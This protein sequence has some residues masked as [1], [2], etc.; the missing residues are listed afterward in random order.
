MYKIYEG[1]KEIKQFDDLVTSVNYAMNASTKRKLAYFDVVYSET[2]EVLVE[3]MDGVCLID[4]CYQ[5]MYPPKE[6]KDLSICTCDFSNGNWG[7][8][9]GH[10]D[11]VR[12]QK[13]KPQE[14]ELFSQNPCDEILL[15]D[16]D[17]PF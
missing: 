6:E 9:C 3:Y 2:G 10:M 17:V 14:K 15:G 4:N 8:T 5:H 16:D 11:W 7:C 1:T 12:E 13:N